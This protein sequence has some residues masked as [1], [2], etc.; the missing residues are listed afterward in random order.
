MDPDTQ[1]PDEVLDA[2][3]R[4][5]AA[6]AAEAEAETERLRLQR[7]EEERRRRE[8][9]ERRLAELDSAKTCEWEKTRADNAA[10]LALYTRFFPSQL[11]TNH[12][13]AWKAAIPKKHT[14]CNRPFQ[15]EINIL[16]VCS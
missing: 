1:Q 14:V 8:E 15:N 16:H 7:E 5:E 2:I 10:A 4:A 12:F 13:I 6:L 3:E 9:E 11:D